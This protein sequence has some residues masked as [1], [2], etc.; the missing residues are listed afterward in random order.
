MDSNRI[1]VII[2][3]LFGV[4]GALYLG[5]SAA[6]A[7]VEAV[8]WVV[9]GVGLAVCLGLGRRIWILLPFMTSIGLVLPIK[10]NFSSM[11]IA[12]VIVIGFCALL[13]LMR[14]LPMIV[15]MTE[16]EIWCIAFGLCVLQAYLRNPVG[17][18]IF[19]GS[20]VGGRPYVMFGIT[21]A[22]SV[23]ISI[24]K[25]P[26]NELR[27]WVNA[28]MLGSMANF[29]LGALARFAPGFGSILGA[30]FA[31][32]VQKDDD[33]SNR[34]A[35]DEG[36]AGRS[37]FVRG[38]SLDL[39]NWICSR[40][41]PLSA[42][43]HPV[44]GAMMAFTLIA[45]AYSGYRSHLAIV[46]FTYVVGVMYRG[47][48]RHLVLGG[49]LGVMALVLLA[50]INLIHPLPPN[51][52]RSLTFLPGTWEER[53]KLDT[54]QS[55]EWRMQ[56]WI[57]ALSSNRY[58]SNRLLGDGLGMSAEQFAKAEALRYAKD[59]GHGSFDTHRESAMISGDYHSGPV[60]TIRTCGYLGLVVLLFGLIRLAVHAH[61][62]IIRCRNTEWF[63][64]ALFIGNTY[65]WFAFGWTFI[66]GSFNGGA[67]ALMLGAALIRL[68][69]NNLPLPA[70]IPPS[71]RMPYHLRR[72]ESSQVAAR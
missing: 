28:T 46:V 35:A 54:Q 41:A 2:I 65:V 62:Q 36:A 10:G 4:F 57:D 1:K 16:L 42:A 21:F 30:S 15:R 64:T 26:P 12:Q 53:Y 3:M 67:N 69:E 9:G 45:A 43:F 44:W 7:Q 61:R 71:R 56:M 34:D 6:T 14:K 13:F 48:L 38:I 58:I 19:G 66:F 31:T 18:N 22:V 59:T 11:L 33:P 51:V 72:V 27:W 70:Y 32:D 55:T 8:L 52:Q 29:F 39:A 25:I 68:L 5:V 60:Q 23:V 24:L 37:S 49:F 50:V 40:V 20:S 47:G 63:P 17:L